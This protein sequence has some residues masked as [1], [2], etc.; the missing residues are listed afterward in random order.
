MKTMLMAL[1]ASAALVLSSPSVAQ[2]ECTLEDWR[3]QYEPMMNWITIEGVSTCETAT[4]ALRVYDENGQFL[5]ADPMA[6]IQGGVFMSIIDGV[7]RRPA[8]VHLKG[9]IRKGWF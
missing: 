1:V 9:S 5:G 6:V 4:M 3:W 8:S 7:A 2:D